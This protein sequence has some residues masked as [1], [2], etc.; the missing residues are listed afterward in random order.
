[1]NDTRII[2]CLTCSIKRSIDNPP[3]TVQT[4]WDNSWNL[5]IPEE[6]LEAVQHSRSNPGHILIEG[7]DYGFKVNGV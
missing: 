2:I 5:L 4:V 3:E 6:E 1:M 7:F